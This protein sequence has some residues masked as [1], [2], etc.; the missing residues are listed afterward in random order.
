MFGSAG[1]C[2]PSSRPS[3]LTVLAVLPGFS[4]GGVG[5]QSS[6][7]LG[8]DLGLKSPPPALMRVD[9][10]SSCWHY[11]LQSLLDKHAARR[12]ALAWLPLTGD[13]RTGGKL[14][15]SAAQ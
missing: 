14:C 5:G 7:S 4:K 9:W 11:Q 13:A 3:V 8:S 15:P 6:L 2:S 1:V 12:M 10:R